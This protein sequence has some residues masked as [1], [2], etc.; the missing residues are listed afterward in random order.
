MRKYINNI[1]TK[2]L[3]LAIL[4]TAPA[5]TDNFMDYNTLPDEPTKL[6]DPVAYGLSL[7]DLQCQVIP[8]R[9]NRYQ[10]SEN[11]LGGVYGRYF[12]TAN[13]SWQQTHANFNAPSS[14]ISAPFD[15]TMSDIYSGWLEIKN[16]SGG[17][18]VNFAW[19]Q[20]IRVAAMH[21][22][23]DMVGPI[24]YTEMGESGGLVTAYDSQKDVYVAMFADLD[25]AIN[26]L[27]TYV[28][29]SPTDRSYAQYDLVYEGDLS[30]WIKFANSLKLRM[31]MRI[32][33]VEPTLA[34]QHAEEALS[35]IYGVITEN[36]ENAEIDYTGTG[37]QNTLWWM[38]SSYNDATSA[39]DIVTYMNSYNDPRI[40]K[41]FSPSAGGGVYAGL[42]VGAFPAE[43][44]RSS[45]SVPAVAKTD[46][47]MWLSASEVAF[48][49]AEMALNGWNAGGT[50]EDFYN[51]GITLSF[52]QNG[53]TE[54]SAATY[55]ADDTLVPTNHTDARGDAS[56]SY[57]PSVPY[58]V[59]I[60]WDDAATAEQKLEKIITQKWIALYP[61]GTEAWS[62]Q[63][64]TGYPRFYPSINNRSAESGLEFVGASRALF[65]ITEQ[66]NNAAN[67]SKAVTLLGG[68]DSY[69]TKLWWDVKTNKPA[70]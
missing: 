44:W 22:L 43:T 24:P 17:E 64:R 12:A 54:G 46:K 51:Q 60:A 68:S 55:Y 30:K 42:R 36:S 15:N 11:L 53:L 65:A 20:V 31:A 32:S 66:E 13:T 45:Y 29:L 10:L 14:W 5:C 56:L 69:G 61:L 58:S 18:G 70:W 67:Y 9:K 1:I 37:D 19:A 26:E 8:A 6:P 34:Q 41:Y 28:T 16:M 21:R 59:T 33:Y 50:A 27:T 35:H 38:V 3:L 4:A 49:R 52:T 62:E 23:T 7:K 39:A 25:A 57:A 40:G 47:M 63:R 48:L 2:V